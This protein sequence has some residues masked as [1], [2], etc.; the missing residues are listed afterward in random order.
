MNVRNTFLM[1]VLPLLGLHLSAHAQS[2]SVEVRRLD[3]VVRTDAT[4][5]TPVAPP[6]GAYSAQF[7]GVQQHFAGAVVADAPYSANAVTETV[8]MLH[9]GNRIRRRNE[10]RLHRDSQGRTRREQ[11]LNT[12]GAWQ[13]APQASPLVFI[14]D[15]VA[16]E[17]FLLDSNN[18]TARRLAVP[19][20]SPLWQEHGD[21]TVHFNGSAA[22]SSVASSPGTAVA[23][24][25]ATFSLTSDDFSVSTEEL[26]ERLFDGV[27]ATG[28]LTRMTIAA[29]TIGNELPIEVVTEQWYSSV[30]QA[31]VYRRHTDPRFGE[32]TYRLSNLSTDEP[33]KAL[34]GVPEGYTIVE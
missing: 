7:V 16:N 24:S 29:E 14:H 6:F 10:A 11:Q 31:I 2:E 19:T 34:F 32:T 8:Q 30:L 26:G 27:P 15:P 4:M 17:G 3:Q 33:D 22:L 21:A 9:D 28:S 12:L 23:G 18:R 5:A 25:M 1:A 13:L 20:V